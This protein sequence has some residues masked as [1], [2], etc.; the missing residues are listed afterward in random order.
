MNRARAF[1]RVGIVNRGDAA[2]RC[3]HAARSFDCRGE[4][5]QTVVLY[6]E[7]DRD[8]P[9]VHHADLAV[10]IE[11]PA[12]PVAAYLDRASVVRVLA[13]HGCEAVWPGW[14]FLA[15]DPSFA[16]L[17]EEAGMVF[18]GP[19]GETMRRLG[20]KIAARRLAEEL[21]VPVTAWSGGEVED[22]EQALAAARAIGF[23]VV[24]KATAGGGGRGIRVVR[25]ENA[26]AAAYESA[27]AEALAAFGDGRVFLEEYVP[28]GR[29]VEVQIIA[30]T[31]GHVLAL[32]CRDC[33]VQRRH[34]KIIEETPPPGLSA[35]LLRRMER[36]AVRLAR[37]VGY[38]GA[39]TV[40]FLVSGGRYSFLEVN[41]RLQ[42]E[43]GVT[44]AV[45]GLDLVHLQF[46]IGQGAKLEGLNVAPRGAAIEARVCAE[47][48]EA[49]FAP[50]PG[51][52]TRFQVVPGPG[53]RVDTGLA[54]G[55]RIPAEF[56]SL[57]AKVIS[58]GATRE[59][60]AARL[61]AAL[62]DMDIAVRGGT[63]N[64]SFLIGVL[65][66]PEFR[67]ANLHTRWLDERR[68][69]TTTPWK[70]EALLC[71]AILIYQ[72]ERRIA[73]A[74]FFADPSRMEHALPPPSLGRSVELTCEG[75]AY[76]PTIYAMGGW[77]YRVHLDGRAV[78]VGLREEGP[79]SALMQFGNAT[80]RIVHDTG[81]AEIRVE[82]DGRAHRFGQ[83]TAG[84]VRASAPCL[85]V[86]V[87][88]E[89]GEQVEK[90]QVLGVLEAMKMEIAFHSPVAGTVREVRVR[91]G[92]QVAAGDVL[93]VVA[94]A[95]TAHSDAS[96]TARERLRLPELGDPLELFFSSPAGT[97]R[98]RPVPDFRRAAQ[99]P[100]AVRRRAVEELRAEV[101]RVLLGYDA[102]RKRIDQLVSLLEAR[103]PAEV[104]RELLEEL[105]ALRAELFAFGDIEQLFLRTPRSRPG[106]SAEPS[107]RARLFAYLRRMH[108]GGAGIAPEFLARLRA[109][110]THYGVNDLA[111]GDRLERAV[112]R[113]LATR[114][115]EGERRRLVTALLRHLAGLAE[116]GVDLSRDAE[117]ASALWTIAELRSLVG[118]ALADTAIEASYLFF[119]GPLLAEQ[120]ERTTRE[121]EEWLQ[122]AER[123]ASQPP[124]EVLAQLA[125]APRRV[126]DRIGSW[127]GDPD[128]RRHALA[129]A[130]HVRRL[131]VPL[132]A[133]T[134]SQRWIRGLLTHLVEFEGGLRVVAVAGA[135]GEMGSVL[136]AGGDTARAWGEV[137]AM[138]AVLLPGPED[139]EAE[140]LRA[141]ADLLGDNLPVRRVTL[142]VVRGEAEPLH[143]TWVKKD[144][145]WE[146]WELHGLHPQAAERVELRRLANFR[147]RR[148][149]AAEGIYC[150]LA[151]SREDPADERVLV[152][153]DIREHSP[154]ND[155]GWH[156]LPFAAFQRAFHDATRTLRVILALRD[157][158][159]RLQ[160]NR[161]SLFLAHP[162]AVDRAA[163]L[164]LAGRLEPATHHL[165]LE[166]VVVRFRLREEGRE[167][168]PVEVVISSPVGGRIDVEWRDPHHA[169]LRPV[170]E[171]ERRVV[172]ARRGGLLHPYE[173]LR[174]LETGTDAGGGI[175]P[176]RFEE[177]RLDPSA[178]VPVAVPA[179]GTPRCGP[180][181]AVLFG[182]LT[183]PTPEVPEGLRR[184][185]VLSDPTRDMGALA[186]AECDCI[187]AALDLAERNG[188]PVEWIPVS[189]GARIAMDSGTENLDATARVA[190]RIVEFTQAGGTIH[191]IVQGVNVGAQSYFDALATML[192]H[193]RGALVMTSRGAM[194]LTGKAALL[195]SG[196]VAAEDE[197]AIG[198]YERVMGPNGEA[199]YFARDIAEAFAILY[200][201]Y[202]YTYVPPG[203]S[204]PRRALSS[205]PPGRD[206]TADPYPPEEE[207]GF[208]RIGD[209]FDDRTN[210][211]RKRPFA[212]RPLMAAL[213]DRDAGHL[214]RWSAWVGAETAIVWDTRVGGIP[215]CLI[216]IE[217]RNLPRFGYRPGDG[218]ESWTGGTLFPLS[219]KKI[220][221]ALNAASG[222]RPVVLL[223]N[224]SGFDGSPESMRKWQLEY[225]AEIA[226]AVVNFRGPILFVV[227]SRYHGGAY[228]VFSRQLN[229]S[230]QSV[231][232][233]GS[234][235]SV[236][237][238]APAA[239]VVF[240]RE[241]RARA[242]ADPRVVTLQEALRRNPSARLREELDRVW[243]EVLPEKRAELA[244]EFDA[245]H[246]VER[247]LRVGS[248]AAIIEPAELRLRVVEFLQAHHAGKPAPQAAPA[249]EIAPQRSR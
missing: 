140:L 76:R 51:T 216:G 99:A 15:E 10:E 191:V 154:E 214:E 135:A 215:V 33:S 116:A 236:I 93:V 157:R 202:R 220:A 78:T 133:Q 19:T 102:N 98:D 75:E 249:G 60:A 178:P 96:G 212:M 122:Q 233:R 91:R 120:A 186:A 239:A 104:G 190:R 44:E 117:L 97:R 14:G 27:R 68:G 112:F 166:K 39:G 223:A 52:L 210:P 144:S 108:A 80:H 235:A 183:T 90:D 225:G 94:P 165:G 65:E 83:G 103:I 88:V 177:Y 119:D 231:A 152:L 2:M 126:F 180:P 184:V 232:L 246:T 121:V 131:Y 125:S 227:I 204:A 37:H 23:P 146:R 50:A 57:V 159:R 228:V 43:H 111:P 130:A 153:A 118:H 89:P 55:S 32:G 92:Q 24:L 64:K 247:A 53:I 73:R 217:G 30:D 70:V 36:D 38:R 149:D 199:Q 61:A 138:E 107:N 195:A 87:D 164:R 224:L 132:V 113:L 237:G 158:R 26:L 219:S 141:A 82:V 226:R 1:T 203:E 155:D 213:A 230:L 17:V 69:P 248:I 85:V 16:D 198:G 105:S 22:T 20:D 241:V 109:A 56:D 143:R 46:R 54:A 77:R 145:G 72:N 115:I 196:S 63:T 84:E 31:H 123:D 150:F 148:I 162:V 169:P 222:N 182:I 86:S 47:D 242:E 40:E 188:I 185:L 189:A 59:E 207:G 244:A 176:G 168:R 95:E 206:I 163:V 229:D 139:D 3:I 240:Q 170:N 13:E 205:D 209:I 181:S 124:S 172:A 49:G 245:V 28:G 151:R 234:Y 173:I 179:K 18:L 174:L 29:H 129:L 71:A 4:R 110:L 142:T 171:E 201:H 58:W 11:H 167:P 79:H 200:R 193:T 221:R 35:D 175:P 7:P 48:P 211:G 8:A 156:P 197:I 136:A 243:R 41:P 12:G 147:L 25:N 101:R 5:L 128:P 106:G 6:T 161:I 66:S 42:V 21:G 208:T 9:F 114:T 62:A 137:L 127:L 74:N 194:V 45:T 218:P 81:P 160:W 192:M 34:Q 187:V 238:G 134:T 67:R 100:A